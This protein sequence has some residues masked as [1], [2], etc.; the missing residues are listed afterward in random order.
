MHTAKG[1]AAVARWTGV[2]ESR[3]EVFREKLNNWVTLPAP[4][5]SPSSS[6][7]KPKARVSAIPFPLASAS[8][9]KSPAKSSVVFPHAFLATEADGPYTSHSENLCF[10]CLQGCSAFRACPPAGSHGR[11]SPQDPFFEREA[12]YERLRQRSL[13]ASPTKAASSDVK[14]GKLTR[15]QLLKMGQDELRRSCY[16]AASVVSQKAFGCSVLAQIVQDLLYTCD[17]VFERSQAAHSAHVRGH[18][19]HRQVIARPYIFGRSRG[20]RN[21]AGEASLPT[22]G[23]EE[24]I[25]MPALS[26]GVAESSP[27]KN[28]AVLIDSATALFPGTHA[29]SSAI[30]VGCVKRGRSSAGSWNSTSDHPPNGG[31]SRIT[32]NGMY[33]SLLPADTEVADNNIDFTS[34]PTVR[35]S[36]VFGQF[37]MM[38][39]DRALFCGT[40]EYSTETFLRLVN[41][42]TTMATSCWR[43]GLDESTLLPGLASSNT[44]SPDGT[45]FLT[46]NDAPQNSE[47]FQIRN[48]VLNEETR[49]VERLQAELSGLYAQSH[50]LQSRIAHLVLR[51]REA[52]GRADKVPAAHVGD[53]RTHPVPDLISQMPALRDLSTLY[54]ADTSRDRAA[55]DLYPPFILGTTDGELLTRRSPLLIPNLRPTSAR[56]AIASSKSDDRRV[57]S[58][59]RSSPQLWQTPLSHN[60]ARVALE[61]ISSRLSDPTELSLTLDDFATPTLIQHVASVFPRLRFLELGHASYVG[62]HSAQLHPDVRDP[63][64]L[65]ALQHFPLLAHLRIALDFVDRQFNPENPQR[66]AAHWLLEGL[67][68][69]QTVAFSWEQRW[70]AYWFDQVVWREWDCSILLRL[71]SPPPRSPSPVQE[72]IEAV[73]IPPWELDGS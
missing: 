4:P 40:A 5:S 65:E 22:I 53:N 45:S 42:A 48:I 15:D 58:R 2:A 44:L 18:S 61:N 50:R 10:S 49:V 47:I 11:D 72:I 34:F 67:P 66:R 46:S 12:L 60:T 73:A 20:F 69:P 52:R 21:N 64:I 38:I 9:Y 30:P 56:A 3:R 24:W 27:S 71:P 28:P 19:C 23:G 37:Y 14:G 13:S 59:K 16:W 36:D 41:N 26:A 35:E 6:P 29:E 63:A 32:R 25:E 39:A 43:C 62:N 51:R 70:F 57:H 33:T 31:K 54:S 8:G 17:R 68:A 7:S 1:M 55:G